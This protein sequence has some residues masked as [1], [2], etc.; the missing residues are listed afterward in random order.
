MN[1][2][3]VRQA[4]QKQ[5]SDLAGTMI[6]AMPQLSFADAEGI[7]GNKGDLVDGIRQLFSGLILRPHY[8]VT[9]N[10]DLTVERMIVIGNYDH[11]DSCITQ[12]H[13]PIKREG[14]QEKEVTLFHFNRWIFREEVIKE[15]SKWGH[16]PAEPE[17][18]LAFG[19]QYRD[20]QRQFPILAFGS[21]WQHPHHKKGYVVCLTGNSVV[22]S[23]YLHLSN[24]RLKPDSC[25]L[26]VRK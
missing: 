1:N 13:F 2:E 14:R 8:V 24:L 9:V 12:E 11:V 20:I 19:A 5:M 3:T 25:F 26:A 10:Y 4:T 23:I 16:Q 18:I 17:D 6:Q 15:M 7:T 22:R 21:P